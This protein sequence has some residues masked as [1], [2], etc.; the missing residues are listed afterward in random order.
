MESINNT[1]TNTY[2]KNSHINSTKELTWVLTTSELTQS[3]WFQL[4]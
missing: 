2:K 3:L 4:T 1:L